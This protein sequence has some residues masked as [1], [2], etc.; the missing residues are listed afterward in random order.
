[1]LGTEFLGQGSRHDL[2]AEA[3]RS[4]E[5]AL[6]RLT[7]RRGNERIDL[8]F[9]LLK[10]IYQKHATTKQRIHANS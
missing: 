4:S 8:H 6:T 1:M 9:T 7:G 3:G 2:P 5:V 10:S